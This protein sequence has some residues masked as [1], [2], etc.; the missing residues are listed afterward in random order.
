MTKL[1]VTLTGL[2]SMINL[3]VALEETQKIS[4]V[5]LYFMNNRTSLLHNRRC[6]ACPRSTNTGESKENPEPFRIGPALFFFNK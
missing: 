2:W 5:I 1:Y 6:E 3:E 4:K